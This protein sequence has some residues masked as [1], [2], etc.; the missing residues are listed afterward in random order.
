MCYD[1]KCS[2]CDWLENLG[3]YDAESG[4]S[5]N[6]C[7]HP[8][9]SSWSEPTYSRIVFDCIVDQSEMALLIRFDGTRDQWVPKSVYNEPDEIEDWFIDENDLVTYRY[10][11]PRLRK[12]SIVISI[13]RKDFIAKRVLKGDLLQAHEFIIVCPICHK[14]YISEG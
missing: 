2:K 4:R 13:S 7:T 3:E 12:D 11:E 6:T 8:Q 1:M 14:M 10:R 5:K 9:R